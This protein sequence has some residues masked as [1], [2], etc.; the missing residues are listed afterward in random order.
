MRLESVMT[1]PALTARTALRSPDMRSLGTTAMAGN[2]F[3]GGDARPRM[4]PAEGVGQQSRTAGYDGYPPAQ[5]MAHRGSTAADHHVPDVKQPVYAHS[6]VYAS[7]AVLFAGEN[8]ARSFPRRASR[9]LSRA[10]PLLRQTAAVR[11]HHE[12]ITGRDLER[13]FRRRRF[14]GADGTRWSR[15]RIYRDKRPGRDS[16]PPIAD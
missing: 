15:T 13:P 11:R 6:N 7:T 10:T 14:R 4:A 8:G 12:P 16:P 3:V 1:E 5:Y 2:L 9:S